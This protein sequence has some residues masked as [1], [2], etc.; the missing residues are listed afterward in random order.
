MERS[1]SAV[2]T[3]VENLLKH[4]K[5]T[6]PLR[7]DE[8]YKCPSFINW[9]KEKLVVKSNTDTEITGGIGRYVQWSGAELL[10]FADSEVKLTFYPPFLDPTN[11]KGVVGEVDISKWFRPLLPASTMDEEGK[12]KVNQGE[13]LFYIGFDRK[14]NLQRVIFP[15]DLEHVLCSTQSYKA[16]EMKGRTLGKLYNSF[17]RSRCNRIILK[18]TKEFNDIR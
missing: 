5:K 6:S 8:Y 3:P 15:I 14:V 7:H 11:I 10:F 1:P 13:A 4:L 18:R 2:H 9:A 17:M 12:L 16:Y